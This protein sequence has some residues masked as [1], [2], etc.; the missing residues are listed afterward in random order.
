MYRASFK[1]T[2]HDA[3][4]TNQPTTLTIRETTLG[5]FS[6]ESSDSHSAAR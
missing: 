3:F 4:Y 5:T 6:R 2:P 1:T